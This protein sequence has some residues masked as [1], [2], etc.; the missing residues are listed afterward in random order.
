M[1][2]GFILGR[3]VM[4]GISAV[5]LYAGTKQQTVAAAEHAQL[6]ESST[7]NQLCWTGQIDTPDLCTLCMFTYYLHSHH[8]VHQVRCSARLVLIPH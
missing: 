4:T 8:N 1:S 2:D 6:H 7:W 3:F 5:A